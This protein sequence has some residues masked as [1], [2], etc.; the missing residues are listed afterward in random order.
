MATAEYRMYLDNEAADEDTLSLFGEIRVDQAIGMAAEAELHLDL[1]VNDEGYWDLMEEGFTQPGARVRVEVK[2]GEE[3]EYVPLIEGT[4]VGQRFHLSAEPESSEMVLI[5]QDDSV[6]LNQDETVELFED[7]RADEIAEKLFDDF[8]LDADVDAMPD[9]GSAL[10][11]F[12]VQRGTAMELLKELAR[13]HGA[14]VYVRPGDEPGVS[15]GVFKYPSWE[16]SDLPELL[17]LGEERNV[18]S[19]RAE[20]DATR[21]LTATAYSVTAAD[22]TIIGSTLDT[23][24]VETLGD[25]AAHDVV[26]PAHTLLARGREEQSDLDEAVF[27][28][29]NVSSF[30]YSAAGEVS[31]DIYEGVLLPYQIVTVAGVGATL[32]GDY[33]ISHVTHVLSDEGYTQQFELKRNAR[34]GASGGAGGL[35]GGLF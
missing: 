14:H 35:I 2:V 28:A 19:F 22:K 3:G 16:P 18:A 29:V 25:E 12:T 5:V 30:A 24:D 32:S 4:V 15:V 27:A 6:L 33:L 9:A 20:F 8:G 21:P 11:R 1:T 23:P 17:L 10:P 7:K 13:N 34:S 26:V 31:A